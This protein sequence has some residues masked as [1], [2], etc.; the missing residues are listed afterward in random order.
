MVSEEALYKTYYKLFLTKDL[1]L[2]LVEI[3]ELMNVNRSTFYNHFNYYEEFVNKAF[4]KYFEELRKERRNIKSNNLFQIIEQMNTRIIDDL[5]RFKT[6]IDFNNFYNNIELF[7]DNL[8][9]RYKL[10]ML[11]EIIN[12]YFLYKNEKLSC[13]IVLEEA[14]FS[15]LIH[16][17]NKEIS[18]SNFYLITM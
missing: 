6:V 17:K 16:I 1:N 18:Y 8:K 5:R 14:F 12:K 15:L 10:L 7:Y 4:D 11:N 13:D 3:L 9:K 2:T